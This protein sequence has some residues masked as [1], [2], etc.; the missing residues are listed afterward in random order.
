MLKDKII[1]VHLG[2]NGVRNREI[3]KIIQMG[4]SDLLPNKYTVVSEE[5]FS[6]ILRPAIT[7]KSPAP[8]VGY[9]E[10]RNNDERK[11]VISRPS[12][13]FGGKPLNVPGSF[14]DYLYKINVLQDALRGHTLVFHFF[15]ENHYRYLLKHP[16]YLKKNDLRGVVPSW[17]YITQ[18]MEKII[19]P[20]NIL[21]IWNAESI[22]E[23]YAAF[24]D[25]LDEDLWLN[26]NDIDCSEENNFDKESIRLLSEALDKE[27]LDESFELDVEVLF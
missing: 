5:E 19:L 13:L 10:S 26:P 1:H 18:A 14:E 21:H 27:Q 17:M 6:S 24:T 9:F 11:F 25:T 4:N 2:A 22:E 23:L 8:I 20:G 16:G 7:K 15:I 3:S 12:F